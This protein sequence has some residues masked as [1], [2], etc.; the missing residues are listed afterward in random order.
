[1]MI[2]SFVLSLAAFVFSVVTRFQV[3]DIQGRQLLRK[4]SDDML[5]HRMT[6][7]NGKYRGVLNELA[8]MESKLNKK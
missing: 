5:D 7:L 2:A 6:E 8:A 1:M 3:E 4:F